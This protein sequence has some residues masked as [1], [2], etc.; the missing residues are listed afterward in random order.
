MRPE[1]RRQR[2]YGHS[3]SMAEQNTSLVSYLD[4]LLSE[5]EDRADAAA[6]P[7]IKGVTP[8]ADMRRQERRASSP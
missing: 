1:Q 7:E 3:A 6:A 8:A 4:T 2:P 5:I